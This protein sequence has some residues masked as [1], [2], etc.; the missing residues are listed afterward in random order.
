VP[1]ENGC[2]DWVLEVVFYLVTLLID[3]ACSLSVEDHGAARAAERFV[4]S[5]SDDIRV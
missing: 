3:A 4:C 2:V 5:C 1:G